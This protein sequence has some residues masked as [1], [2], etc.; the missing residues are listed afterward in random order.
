MSID[1]NLVEWIVGGFFV[2][3]YAYGRYNTPP[4][5]RSTTTYALYSVV[6][7]LYV[8]TLW[9]IYWLFGIVIESSPK[10]VA[11]IMTFLGATGFLF[12]AELK[13]LTGPI[14]AALVLSAFLPSFPW[15]KNFDQALL[16]RF[17]D[18]GQIPG[19]SISL[20]NKMRR[21]PY[22]V[23]QHV[24]QD[25]EAKCRSLNIAESFL[26]FEVKTTPEFEWTRVTSLIVQLETWRESPSN[27][28][29]RYVE[30]NA[31]ELRDI[32]TLYNDLVQRAT[33]CLNTREQIDLIRNR[34]ELVD[35]QLDV[36][37][38]ENDRIF[39]DESAKIYKI[40]CR[41]IARATLATGIWS[42]KRSQF[43]VNMGFNQDAVRP[44]G[45]TLNQ[46]I[47]VMLLVTGCFFAIS[48]FEAFY[49]S[50]LGYAVL[51]FKGI[52]FQTV[53]MSASFGGAVVSSLYPKARWDFANREAVGTRPVI[54][55]LLSG[56]LAIILGYLTMVAVRYSYN[57]FNGLQMGDNWIKVHNDLSWSY[58]YLFQSF[59][60]GVV[61]AF[62]A[63]NYSLIEGTKPRWLRWA[64]G[65]VLLLAAAAAS[66]VTYYWME[67]SFLFEGTK[68][69][70]YRGQISLPFFILKGA[71]VGFIIGV[72]VPHW[73]RLNKQIPPSQ[74]LNLLMLDKREEIREEWRHIDCPGEVLNGLL[75]ASAHVASSDGHVDDIER[76]Q[77]QGFLEQLA[78]IHEQ[79]FDLDKAIST[80]N[81]YANL[82]IDARRKG[83]RPE[84]ELKKEF[85][86][87]EIFRGRPTL[88]KMLVYL[89]LLVGRSDS[90]FEVE[91]LATVTAIIK[92]LK[93][94]LTEYNLQFGHWRVV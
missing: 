65:G 68:L 7:I 6:F 49:K 27:S 55:Y 30:E 44:R 17:W 74:H 70:Q 50:Y 32:H 72:L 28:I 20:A 4:E 22:V 93:L 84:E 42:K 52:A 86:N 62:L 21:A 51:G 64:D 8:L 5:N 76:Q 57:L 41:F 35:E 46:L 58:P 80:F 89:C 63:D 34:G 60:I 53:L 19:N 36:L 37:V 1:S 73:Y 59:T 3:V 69:K 47:S 83:L 48:V 10:S 16:Q 82:I 2:S 61:T 33:S 29:R 66:V 88:S 94:D 39:F 24:K 13:S 87:L 25:V 38:N 31:S 43:L 91:E 12:P 77:L 75:F 85:E 67:S 14:V 18:L 40:I 9:I 15:I 23:P 45:I 54:G 11:A 26:M 81:G 92:A 56:L 90:M 71:A 78:N 79:P